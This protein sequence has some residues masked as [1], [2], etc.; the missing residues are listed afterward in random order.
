MKSSAV[1]QSWRK[2]D[3]VCQEEMVQAL[4]GKDP[5]LV[6]DQGVALVQV[7]WVETAPGQVPAGIVCVPV[8][9]QRFLTRQAFLAIT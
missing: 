6:E 8:V 5:E 3:R 7:E 2:G 1:L 4:T 9:E